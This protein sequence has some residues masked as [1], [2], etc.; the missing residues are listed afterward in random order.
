[1]SV[2]ICVVEM[3]ETDTSCWLWCTKIETS[4][5][6]KN[7]TDKLEYS[8]SLQS[9]WDAQVVRGFRTITYPVVKKK[10]WKGETKRG[11][12]T[13][14]ITTNLQ[15]YMAVGVKNGSNSRWNGCY[16]RFQSLHS[17]DECSSNGLLMVGFSSYID[18][19]VCGSHSKLVNFIWLVFMITLNRSRSLHYDFSDL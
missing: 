14:C 1:M 6:S 4:V 11:R 10:T 12:I 5:A 13:E 15:H 17:E 7:V 2:Q 8:H 18:I 19:N 3:K 16:A 9:R